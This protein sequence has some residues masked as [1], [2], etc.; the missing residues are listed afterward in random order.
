MAIDVNHYRQYFPHLQNKNYLDH[1]SISPLSTP[2]VTAMTDF[3]RDRS[4]SIADYESCFALATELRQLLARLI[5]AES[6]KTIAFVGNTTLGLNV[7]AQ[8][9]DWQAGDRVLM[10]DR[11]FPANVYPYLNLRDQG[12]IVDFVTSQNG[13]VPT[14]ELLAQVKPRTQLVSLSLV[15]FM[16]GYRHDAAVIGK[17]C[18][19]R[20]I[21]FA[22]DAIQ[23]L[24]VVQV[25]VQD[26]HVDFLAAGAQK[27]LMSPLGSAFIYVAPHLLPRLRVANLGWLSM[28]N[29]WN[30]FDYSIR[31]LDSAARFEPGTLPFSLLHGMK[32][33]MQIIL[34]L[35]AAELE[36]RI[37][38]LSGYLLQRLQELGFTTYT[39]TTDSE[40]AGIVLFS[41]GDHNERIWQH[42]KERGI[43]ISLRENLLRVSPHFYNTEEDLDSFLT[44]LTELAGK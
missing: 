27:W 12:V 41:T 23:A 44:A 30:F 20:G 26:C 8:G 42:L 10:T 32:A 6:A 1:A 31:L 40:R 36:A 5:H 39:P 29:S 15:E 34:S 7:L 16:S 24:G 13:T 35:P 19:E 9:L 37:L 25:D 14:G 17:F 21:L 3:L 18:H 43:I 33:A 4:C 2:V 11:E 22:L 28:D 38:H